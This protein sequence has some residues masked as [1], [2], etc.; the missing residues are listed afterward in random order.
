[1]YQRSIYHSPESVSVPENLDAIAS[2]VKFPEGEL[3]LAVSGGADSAAM[4]A[5]ASYL[6]RYATLHHVNHG[7]REASKAEEDIVRNLGS[8]FGFKVHVYNVNMEGTSEEEAR[9]KRMEHLKGKLTAHSKNDR[10]ETMLYNMM[11]GAGSRGM[12]S[13]NGKPLIDVTTEE[14]DQ[15]CAF[16]N[17][18]LCVDETNFTNQYTRN[19][20]RYELIPLMEDISS[21]NVVEVLNRNANTLAKESE[22]LD[23]LASK[24]NIS[25]CKAA[26]KEDD[27]ILT[28]A[29]KLWLEANVSHNISQQNIESV[30]QVIRGVTV[31]TQVCGRDIRRSSNVLLLF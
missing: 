1:M 18:Q 30:V 4:V 22:F 9:E 10:V 26:Q 27:V 2:K 31:G 12:S 7:L 24:V 20:V 6:K 19:R 13:M 17:L 25:D 21:R 28:R 3:H 11:R 15:V 8:K 14:L 29:V 5:L 23:K 16:Y